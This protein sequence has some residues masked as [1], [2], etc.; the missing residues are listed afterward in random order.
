[1]EVFFYTDFEIMLCIKYDFELPRNEKGEE[2]K[3]HKWTKKQWEKFKTNSK[4]EFHLSPM[5][6]INRIKAYNFAKELWEK[7]L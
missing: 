4:V 5:E 6:E 7:F 3:E 1:M 2:L